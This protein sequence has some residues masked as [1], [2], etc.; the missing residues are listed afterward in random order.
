MDHPARVKRLR[1]SLP[2]HKLD[3]LLVTHLPNVRYLCGF[4]GSSAALLIG[5][6]GATLF[7]DGRYIA[8]AHAE[9]EG[10]AIVITRKAPHLAAADFLAQHS[11][12]GKKVIGI[13]ADH[14]PVALAEQL[15][16]RLGGKYKLASRISIAEKQRMIKDADEI[17][18]I[19][20]AIDL[21][22]GL[23]RVARRK[24][25]PGA[26]EADVA[27][28]MEYEARRQGSDGM[29]FPTIIASGKRSALPH[30]RASNARIP[31]ARFV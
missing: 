3:L 17:R 18:S 2:A 4:T 10:V 19:R 7:T 1:A 14:L 6:R 29:S 21:G 8:Q 23:F 30:G 27:G 22:A 20:R 25:R 26:V 24:I 12:S 11:R 31:R 15:S 16:A 9:A 28:A 13:E 5:D